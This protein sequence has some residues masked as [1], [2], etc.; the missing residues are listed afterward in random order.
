MARFTFTK[1]TSK[2]FGIGR[3]RTSFEVLSGTSGR[4]ER[5]MKWCVSLFPAFVHDYGKS[6]ASVAFHYDAR[7]CCIRMSQCVHPGA[8]NYVRTWV[9]APHAQMDTVSPGSTASLTGC[10]GLAANG[11]GPRKCT[12]GV[13]PASVRTQDKRTEARTGP[14]PLCPRNG[15][16]HPG[17]P[18]VT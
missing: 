5:V 16:P 4:A 11:A 13:T 9:S 18:G 15:R 14:S 12:A 2:H 17:S 3:S 1:T 8:V 7:C 6:S 10:A